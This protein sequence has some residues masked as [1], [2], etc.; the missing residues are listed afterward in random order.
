LND[1]QS[2]DE[3]NPLA[4]PDAVEISIL[5]LPLEVT[6]EPLIE[7]PDVV[8]VSATDVTVPT[9]QLRFADKSYAVPFIVSV[10]DEGT[11]PIDMALISCQDGAALLPKPSPVWDRNFCVA[12]VLPASL[13]A[14]PDA[15]E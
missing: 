9:D 4:E 15:L 7:M 13:T 14:A 2:L 1:V 10:L 8:V 11:A 3:S 6:G 5:R 12:D